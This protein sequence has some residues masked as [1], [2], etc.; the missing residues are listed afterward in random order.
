MLLFVLLLCVFVRTLHPQ[1][2]LNTDHVARRHIAQPLP[3]Q[4][5]SLRYAGHLRSGPIVAGGVADLLPEYDGKIMRRLKAKTRTD[6]CNRQVR[7][8]QQMAG[9]FKAMLQVILGRVDG[10]EARGRWDGFRCMAPQRHVDLRRSR[11]Q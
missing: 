10:V 3:K 4:S 5:N 1:I 8:Y 6:G 9:P 2:R 7:A 11:R